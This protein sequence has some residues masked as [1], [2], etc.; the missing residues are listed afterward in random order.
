MKTRWWVK[1][2]DG[3]LE[4]RISYH[5]Y[6]HAVIGRLCSDDHFGVMSWH[7]S[8]RVAETRATRQKNRGY[9]VQIVEVTQ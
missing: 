3:R 2:P 8:K 6:T 1:L 4:R 5:V 9:D 7:R